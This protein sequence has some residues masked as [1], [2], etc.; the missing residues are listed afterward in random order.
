MRGGAA[1]MRGRDRALHRLG[2]RVLRL[3][4][5]LVVEQPH[6]ALA[7]IRAALGE[8][9]TGSGVEFAGE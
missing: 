7:R 4:A 3:E 1:P 9:T 5:E 8:M 6:E 2:Y